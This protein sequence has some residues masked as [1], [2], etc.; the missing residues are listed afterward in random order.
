[1]LLGFAIAAARR[2]ARAGLS[3]PA[4]SFAH[5]LDA[6]RVLGRCPRAAARIV[7]WVGLAMALR[8]AAAAGIAAAF[9][10][11]R[12]LAAALLIIPALDLAGLLPLTPGNVGR[13]RARPSRLH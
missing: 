6:F 9:G 12:P 4:A 11:D 10:I 8:I 7:G 13:R 1:M 3:S 5:S 2:V